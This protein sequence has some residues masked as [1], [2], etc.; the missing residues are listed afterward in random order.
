MAGVKLRLIILSILLASLFVVPTVFAQSNEVLTDQTAERCALTQSYLKTIQKPR[1]L[2]ARVDRLQ[3]Y[4]YISSHLDAFT[5]RLERNNQPG[6]TELRDTL[7]SLNSAIDQFRTSYEQYDKAR[8]EVVNVKDCYT[9]V[10][11][12]QTKLN[13]ARLKRQDVNTSVNAIQSLLVPTTRDQL[14][15]V[16]DQLLASSKTSGG[17]N[18]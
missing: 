7:K 14:T 11:Q 4:I 10:A 13:A 1:D 5:T 15:S 16:Y 12:F 6:A 17:S 2:K 9:N 18:D 3:A 8:E